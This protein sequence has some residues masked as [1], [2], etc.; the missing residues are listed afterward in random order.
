L[1]EKKGIKGDILKKLLNYI[2]NAKKRYSKII[3]SGI[4]DTIEDCKSKLEKNIQM[5]E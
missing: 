4:I 2:N 1:I 3:N 5:L